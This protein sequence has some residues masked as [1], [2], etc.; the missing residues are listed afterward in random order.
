MC[1]D[2][3]VVDLRLVQDIR[4][5]SSDFDRAMGSAKLDHAVCFSVHYGHEF[6]LKSLLLSGLYVS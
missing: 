5:F 1:C 2:V 4:T 3:F 6:R